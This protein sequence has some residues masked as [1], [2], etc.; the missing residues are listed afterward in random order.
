MNEVERFQHKL[1][2]TI[3]WCISKDWAANPTE[4]LCTPQLLLPEITN[5]QRAIIESRHV[6]Q[7]IVEQLAMKPARSYDAMGNMTFRNTNTMTAHTCAD[8][9]PTMATMSYDAHKQLAS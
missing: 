1:G 2:E 6:Q 3:A 8:S 9:T 5:N 4:R 7:E